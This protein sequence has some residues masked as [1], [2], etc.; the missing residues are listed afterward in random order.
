[1]YPRIVYVSV[2]A[3]LTS[4]QTGT[5]Q[6]L[7]ADSYNDSDAY[8]VY[9]AVLPLIWNWELHEPKSLVFQEETEFSS[10]ET[11][12]DLCVKG[13]KKFRNAWGSTLKAYVRA[14]RSPKRLLPMF[15]VDKTYILV[16]KH[17]LNDLILKSH[18]RDFYSRYPD[19]KS[20]VFM[21][22]VGFNASKTKAMLT[23]TYACGS[24]CAQGTYYLMEKQNAKW[25]PAHLSNVT[26][27]A[28]AS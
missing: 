5:D 16:A 28:W 24:L 14:N 25:V 19:S 11:E 26:S 23:M 6:D 18:W 20:Y 13:D 4:L 17:E 3:L 22:S 2:L 8:S 9:A 12:S 21:S 10:T 7:G 1:M 15:P 27:C